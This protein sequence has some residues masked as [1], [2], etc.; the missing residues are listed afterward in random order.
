MFNNNSDFSSLATSCRRG[1]DESS[2]ANVYL[3]VRTMIGLILSMIE[4]LVLSYT[5]RF[6]SNER[7]VT[8]CIIHFC[9]QGVSFLYNGAIPIMSENCCGCECYYKYKNMILPTV[10]EVGLSLKL[11]SM[12]KKSLHVLQ[13]CQYFGFKFESKECAKILVSLRDE[14][15]DKSRM[16]NIVLSFI[17]L[18]LFNQSTNTNNTN[19][20]NN[21]NNN[22]DNINNNDNN[23]DNNQVQVQELKVESPLNKERKRRRTLEISRMNSNDQLFVTEILKT[24]QK[25]YS[26]DIEID[27][28]SMNFVAL[29]F[30]IYCQRVDVIEYLLNINSNKNFDRFEVDINELDQHG[31]SLL[32]F[33]CQFDNAQIVQLLIKYGA[34]VNQHDNFGETPLMSAAGFGRLNI[35]KVLIKHGVDVDDCD[36]RGINALARSIINGKYRIVEYL[37]EYG[38]ADVNY[39]DN[40]GTTVL[41]KAAALG[42]ANTVRLLARHGADVFATDDRGQTAFMKLKDNTV[43]DSKE[44]EF[45]Y[46]FLANT[47]EWRIERLVWI[48]YW[49]NDENEQ[50][51]LNHLSKDVIMLMLAFVGTK[52]KK[53]R[54]V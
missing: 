18:L 52:Y 4:G 47:L 5:K 2:V 46:K 44:I 3:L 28:K 13:E 17:F 37:I 14:Y 35:V 20:I 41:M 39:C 43:I 16:Q 7:I 49:K 27:P 54:L 8:V 11:S 1:R 51:L 33:A 19:D 53:P 9:L 25:K 31:E 15:V 38:K 50:C 26:F 36:N 10:S 30:S 6:Y 42:D 23:T 45:L 34:N 12:L 40:N 29:M 21:D 48:G 24:I 32:M 22:L